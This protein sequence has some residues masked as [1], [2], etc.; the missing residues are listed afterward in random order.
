MSG[1]IP[2]DDVTISVGGNSLAGWVS[3]N[4]VRSLE[5]MPSTFDIAATDFSPFQ[6][7]Q[8]KA[9]PGDPV[10]V[11]I[12]ADTILTGYLDRLAPTISASEH[13][14]RL[15]GR[16][17]CA[18]LVDSN[19]DPSTGLNF[20][21]SSG[22]IADLANKL[23]T[24]FGI[25]VK[26]QTS[27]TLPDF[28]QQPFTVMLTDTPYGILER[29]ARYSGVLI[30]DDT[31][32]SLILSDVGTE[33]AGSD[34]IL[35]LNIESAS[36]EFSADQRFQNYW[37][38]L[39]GIF[40]PQAEE[41]SPY[42]TQS[43][44]HA[45]DPAVQRTRIKTVE[46]SM[47]Q[48]PFSNGE[49]FATAEANWLAARRAGRSFGLRVTTDSWRDAAGALWQP[50]VLVGLD[51]PQIGIM[52]GIEP[53][54]KWIIGSVTFMRDLGSGTTCEL[55][56]M[57]SAAFSV[58]PLILLDAPPPIET[59]GSDTQQAIGAGNDKPPTAG[60]TAPAGGSQGFAGVQGAPGSPSGLPPVRPGSGL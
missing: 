19:L 9:K 13:E 42:I 29:A 27:R 34:L 24:P 47:G 7:G 48:Q 46:S 31:D 49:K 44:G 2:N 53:G 56:L 18:D 33:S 6:N 59:K 55:M 35:G 51:L 52:P 60:T 50:N 40:P 39:Q 17:K 26:V 14:I 16:S 36:A 10:T 20:V 28:G 23:C 43:L 5:A 38:V 11:S 58:E 3:V 45:T 25:G 21:V 54:T 37:V 41:L 1:S 12:G 57:P 22:T 8:F 15:S 4:I 32:G 30:F